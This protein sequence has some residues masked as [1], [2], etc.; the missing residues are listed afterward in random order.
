MSENTQNQNNQNQ[1]TDRNDRPRAKV[2]PVVFNNVGKTPVGATFV[3]T[4]NEVR[5]AIFDLART[6]FEGLSE[7]R[8]R[9]SLVPD[10][11]S[12]KYDKVT[13]TSRPTMAI[14][15]AIYFDKNDTNFVSP[16]DNVFSP[17]VKANSESANKFIRI[18]GAK[19][20]NDGDRDGRPFQP[21]SIQK[22]YDGKTYRC[23]V[24]DVESIVVH[25][26]DGDGYRYEQQYGVKPPKVKISMRPLMKDEGGEPI[27]EGF[28]ITKEL[29]TATKTS[30]NDFKATKIRGRVPRI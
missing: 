12:T 11:N 15:F 4:V 22:G 19:D 18:F 25:I 3:L 2:A 8:V 29:A 14:L 30:F 27:L 5:K 28:S 1:N 20:E 26:V 16:V 24:L 21:I 23:L 7:D 9:V 10:R 6:Y 17:M 13:K